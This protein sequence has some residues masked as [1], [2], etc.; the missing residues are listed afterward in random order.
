MGSSVSSLHRAV[1]ARATTASSRWSNFSHRLEASWPP[2]SSWITPTVGLRLSNNSR[3]CVF[4]GNSENPSRFNDLVVFFQFRPHRDA[5]PAGHRL[6]VEEEEK[7]DV[8]AIP[9]VIVQVDLWSLLFHLR[10]HASA[11]LADLTLCF[12]GSEKL[13]AGMF[14]LL[15]HECYKVNFLAV[16]QQLHRHPNRDLRSCLGLLCGVLVGLPL[17]SVLFCGIA[18]SFLI[19]VPLR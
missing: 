15:A 18:D 4:Q 8:G 12:C 5:L 14:L 6:V 7:R 2:C 19:L 9:L 13:S 10:L 16:L 1:A 11:R 3:V 17:C